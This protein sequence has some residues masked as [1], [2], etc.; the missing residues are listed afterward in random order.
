M[1]TEIVTNKVRHLVGSFNDRNDDF[2]NL[3]QEY[4]KLTYNNTI[5]TGNQIKDFFVNLNYKMNIHK[6]DHTIIGD[7]RA[8]ILL[9]G[10]L[11]DCLK[12]ITIFILL[13]LDNSKKYWIH[14]AIIQI[15]D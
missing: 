11:S 4:S 8:N 3:W 5:Y 1:N 6:Y 2:F 12:N 7:R 13:A 9:S 14:S 15:F 10:K